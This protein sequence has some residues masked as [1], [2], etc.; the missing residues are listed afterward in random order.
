M[1]RRRTA[2]LARTVLLPPQPCPCCTASRDPAADVAAFKE[3]G[4]HVLVGTPGRLDDIM[5]RCSTMDLRTGG[6]L[7]AH[8]APA[9]VRCLHAGCTLCSC[10]ILPAGASSQWRCWCWM[11]PTAFWTWASRRSWTPSCGAFRGSAGQV[12]GPHR[13]RALIV[14]CIVETGRKGSEQPADPPVKPW[15][16]LQACSAPRKRRQLRRWLGRASATLVG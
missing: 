8:S 16:C 1:Q 6:R 14:Q 11:K 15:F 12:P 3:S 13:Q 4:G 2:A 10:H 5:Q 7:C 9:G